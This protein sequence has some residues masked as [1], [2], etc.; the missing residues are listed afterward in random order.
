MV[1]TRQPETRND[2]INDEMNRGVENK[3]SSRNSRVVKP[4]ELL[5]NPWTIYTS[6]DYYRLHLVHWLGYNF[7]LASMHALCITNA[8]HLKDVLFYI[9]IF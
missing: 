6:N 5:I 3:R 1:D 2:I 4:F 9:L 7:S 8:T